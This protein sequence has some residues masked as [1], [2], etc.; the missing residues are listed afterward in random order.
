MGNY[1]GLDGKDYVVYRHY[2]EVVDSEELSMYDVLVRLRNV[3]SKFGGIESKAHF[4]QTRVFDIDT[5]YENYLKSIQAPQI[6]LSNLTVRQTL[7]FILSYINAL[8]RL[9]RLNNGQR[10]LLT[11]EKFNETQGVF[12]TRNI[13]SFEGNQTTNE[14]GTRS[15]SIQHQVLP[16]NM[17]EASVFAPSKDNYLQPRATAVQATS[18]NFEL[19]LPSDKPIYQPKKLVVLV[20]YKYINNSGLI[21]PI[22][23]RELVFT[24]VELDL[25]NRFIN[26]EEWKKMKAR[27]NWL[28][29]VSYPIWNKDIGNSQ[30][31][32][33]YLYWQQGDT[34]IKLSDVYG[35][36]FQ[37]NLVKNVI[38]EA[39]FEHFT[40]NMPE[41]P[42]RT[43][44]NGFLWK[45]SKYTVDSDY[46]SDV[47]WKSLRFNL[48]YISM[49]NMI[50]NQD[51]EDLTQV[52]FYSEM[53]SNQDENIINV[54]RSSRKMYSLL[55]RTG[56]F[57]I[58]F[59]KIHKKT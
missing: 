46:F 53:K 3:V 22:L 6:Y 52:N 48:E 50:V 11:L 41:P 29:V 51:K 12:E 43:D 40:K 1:W 27:T 26:I 13:T 5:Q 24:N 36:I 9:V 47:D 18:N 7:V 30:F 58:T 20:S 2:I 21:T 39:I 42:L 17:S 28:N 56:N 37:T 16:N 49:E 4:E 38:K 10:D 8:P 32:T 33:S 35:G 23:P 15:K 59:A 45:P 44:P 14:I 54:V 31:K 34:V 57:D 19:K 25:T 55:Q